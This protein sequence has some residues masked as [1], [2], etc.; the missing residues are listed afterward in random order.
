MQAVSQNSVTTILKQPMSSTI[1]G[2]L[3]R[4]GSFPAQQHQQTQPATS[5]HPAPVPLQ[6]LEKHPLYLGEL[7]NTLAYTIKAYQRRQKQLLEAKQQQER[8]HQKLY[9]A[10][11]EQSKAARI[12]KPKCAADYVLRHEAEVGEVSFWQALFNTPTPCLG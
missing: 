3:P 5:H 10:F 4:L 6:Y 1:E 2:W 12:K 8:E 7:P 9:A 11:L